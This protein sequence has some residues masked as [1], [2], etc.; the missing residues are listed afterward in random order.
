[1]YMYM[2]AKWAKFSPVLLFGG[3]ISKSF[4]S[5]GIQ[6][7]PKPWDL[8]Q[9]ILHC[10]PVFVNR[11]LRNGLAGGPRLSFWGVVNSWQGCSHCNTQLGSMFPSSFHCCWQPL[12]LTTWPLHRL[13]NVAAGFRFARPSHGMTAGFPR[14][15]DSREIERV[16][17]MEVAVFL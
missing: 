14:A 17:R 9:Q 2:T 4:T 13:P 11:G 3:C 6:I 10:L 12:Q 7:V 5:H 8:K 16:C 15:S 1:M